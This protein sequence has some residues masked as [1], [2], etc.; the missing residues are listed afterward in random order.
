MGLFFEN[1]HIHK[2]IKYNAEVLKKELTKY[3]EEKGFKLAAEGEEGNASVV[4]YE[5]DGS[6]W[7]SVASDIFRLDT[8]EE[9]RNVAE[10]L[11]KCLETEILTAGCY[12][13]DYLRLSILNICDGTDGW[14]NV[15]RAEGMKQLRRTGITPWKKVVADI[16]ALKNIV[17]AEYV[18]AEDAFYKIA[19]LIQMTPEQV[20]LEVEYTDSLAVEKMTTLKFL[21][22]E[23]TL[24]LPEL[25]I[26][27]YNGMPCK[28]GESQVVSVYNNGGKAKGLGIMFIGDYVENDEITFEEVKL[29]LHTKEGW[30]F[31][32]IELKKVDWTQGKKCYYWSDAEFPLPPAVSEAIPLMRRMSLAFE[33][34]IG[35]RFTPVGNP[36]KVLDIKVVVYPLANSMDGQTSWYVYRYEGSK[37]KY[38]E[39]YN[40]RWTDMHIESALKD[41]LNPDD[42]DLE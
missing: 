23:G 26:P 24:K 8:L 30:Q 41:L 28:I 16:D 29:Q 20:A 10:P 33:R 11:S 19:E 1:I 9:I 37:R 12:D 4:I 31:V 38:I 13:S 42:Y 40:R 36:R 6:E 27:R 17:K 21:A 15:G 25:I 14:I 18:F 35:I 22:P 2:N 7:I 34:E 39:E 3:F 32:P 5:P